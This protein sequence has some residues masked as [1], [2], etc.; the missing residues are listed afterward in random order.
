MKKALLMIGGEYHPF[1]SC[2]KILADFLKDNGSADCT[3]TTDPNTFTQLQ[4]YDDMIVYAQGS[5]LTD[6]QEKSLCDWVKNGGAL[7]GI[8]CA[9]DSWVENQRY[10]EMIGSQFKAHGPVTEFLAKISDLSHEITRNINEFRITDEFYIH[11][12]RT[13]K[14]LHWLMAGH[15]RGELHPLAYVRKYGKGRVFYTALGHDERAFNHPSF[16]K[17]IHRAIF[18]TTNSIKPGPVRCGVIGYGDD[19]GM[20]KYHTEAIKNTPLMELTAVCDSD[21][22]RCQA[23]LKKYKNIETYTE[24]KEL[25]ASGNVDTAFIVTPHDTHTAIAIELLQAGVGVICEKPFCISVDEANKMIEAAHANNTL[26]TV[27][28]NRRWDNDYLT[29]KKIIDQ[30]LIGEVFHIEACRSEYQHPGYAWRSHKPVSGGAIYDWGAHFVE[31]ILNLVPYKMES[32]SGFYS[33]HIWHDVT[34]EDHCQAVIRFEGGRSAELEISSL[35][36]VGKP[37]WRILGTK[38]GITAD[39]DSPIYVTSYLRG[40]QEKIEVPLLETRW[41]DFYIGIVDHMLAGEPLHITPESA[42]RVIAV[43]E[44]AEKSS[45]T[46]NTEPVPFG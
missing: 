30:G 42:R 36:A 3:I 46:G 15:W 23:A 14:D 40:S 12:T 13:K 4:D 19:P 11:Q 37:K 16:Q 2:A 31:W 18:W 9:S 27:F 24:V 6:N 43:F 25:A 41:E 26:L 45:Q 34:N 21:P 7:V 33:K 5:K 29:I 1:E 8:H 38:G 20:G 44:A 39:W 32:V 10:M 35:A 17:L 22:K 28:H